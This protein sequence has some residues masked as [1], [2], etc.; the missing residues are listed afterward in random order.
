MK[1]G[2][3]PSRRATR[4]R[5]G[6]P[7]GWRDLLALPSTL[8]V[9]T[10]WSVILVCAWLPWETTDADMPEARRVVAGI[11]GYSAVGLQLSLF[12]L[13]SQLAAAAPWV[14]QAEARIVHLLAASVVAGD[15]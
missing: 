15:G 6:G 3:E 11:S 12:A 4:A 13:S 7:P 5:N 14:R 10:G 2:I 8:T 1:I 9:L